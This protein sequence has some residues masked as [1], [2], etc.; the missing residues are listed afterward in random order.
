LF[1]APRSFFQLKKGGKRMT[2]KI[3]ADSHFLPRH[4][5]FGD[6]AGLLPGF[7][8]EALDM[9]LRDSAVFADPDVRRGGFG[10][11][12]AGQRT[13]SVTS[14]DLSQGSRQ[15]RPIG[16][17]DP[18]QRVKLL[19]QTGFEMQV[20]IPDGPFANPFGSPIA[21]LADAGV[22]LAM[23]KGYNNASAAAQRKH[24]NKLIGTAVVP[25]ND[26]EESCKE[27]VRA[28]KELDLRAITINGNWMG[29]NLDS[30]ELYPFWR[31]VSELDVALYVHHNPFNCQVIDHVPTTYTLGGERLRRLHISN[32]LGFAFEYMV[33][34]ASLTLGG[35]LKEFPSLRLCF[36]EAGG[37]WLPWLMYTL[38]RVYKV[39]PQCARITRPPSEYIRRSCL[40]AVEPDE[41]CL[42]QAV[43]AIGSENFI[44][45]SDYPH[46]PSTFP[47]TAAGIEE[48]QG[49]SP[50][51]QENILGKNIARVLKIT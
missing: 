19:P 33:A 43:A 32:Y 49:L 27:A 1:L 39:E 6:L 50:Q 7:S 48:M 28:V 11:T 8:R 17:G 12:Q 2:R 10:A 31:T 5:D 14:L 44:I 20:L 26:V 42:P 47:N 21:R 24:P 18:D 38:D 23:C 36:F 29:R 40:V 30:L 15:G 35:V 16:H 51:D 45:G 41:F 13:G 46:P 9:V 4:E 25:F 37:S 22:R 3:D 34:M